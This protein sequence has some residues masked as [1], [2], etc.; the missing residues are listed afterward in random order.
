MAGRGA[1]LLVV[2]WQF[3]LILW[4]NFLLQIR[5]PFGTVAELAIPP[6]AVVVLIIMRFTTFPPEDRCFTTFPSDPLTVPLPNN[7]YQIFY[8]P[9][10]EDTMRIEQ[11]IS[12]AL[13][14]AEVTGVDSEDELK[15]N[16]TEANVNPPLN[17]S[18]TLELEEGNPDTEVTINSLA[19][20]F[21]RGAGIVFDDLDSSDGTLEYTLRLRHEVGDDDSWETRRA[22]PRFQL[23]GPRVDQNFYLSEGFVHLESIVGEAIIRLMVNPNMKGCEGSLDDISVSMRQLPYPQ[24][25][26]DVFLTIIITILPLF[27]IL[28]YIYSA[29][30]FTKELVLEKESR[31]RES[32]LMMGLQQWVLW[33]TWFLKQFVILFISA[34]FLVSLLKLGQV[35]PRSDFFLLLIFFMLFIISA[36]SFSFL[37]R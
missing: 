4:K 14:F 3:L 26:V 36:I 29:G 13:P 37:L 18:L 20:C 1:Q 6:L 30:V 8:T 24:Y 22:G 17:L 12:R 19:G 27:V 31:I 9:V 34:F 32:M 2:G 28:A 23:P 16:L 7:T 35:F 15:G 21:I 5:R 11:C 25:T 33:A 10:N